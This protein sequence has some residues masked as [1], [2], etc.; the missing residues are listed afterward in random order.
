MSVL[1]LTYTARSASNPVYN[2]LKRIYEQQPAPV[3]WEKEYKLLNM[4]PKRQGFVSGESYT[5]EVEYSG[6][7]AYQ[8]FSKS[9]SYYNTSNWARFTVGDTDCYSEC[10]LDA[11]TLRRV[12][13]GNRD[14]FVRDLAVSYRKHM[15]SVIKRIA[16]GITRDDN[17]YIGTISAVD[18]SADTITMTMKKDAHFFFKGQK[19]RFSANANG[20][21]PRSEDTGSGEDWVVEAVNKTTGVITLEGIKSGTAITAGD[22]VFLE[23]DDK[24]T[25]ASW[26]GLA[27][28]I[29]Y[30]APTLGADS[31]TSSALDRGVAPEDLAGWRFDG[32]SLGLD[33]A[34][35]MA[36]CDGSYSGE[37]PTHLAMAPRQFLELT[38]IAK[39]GVVREPRDNRFGS[40]VATFMGPNGEVGIISDGTIPENRVYGL[41]LET[42]ELL[43]LTDDLVELSMDDGL[44]A[45]RLADSDGMA[46]RVRSW[47]QLICRRPGDNFVIG[48]NT[49]S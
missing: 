12:K 18:H 35:E 31:F 28:W 40:A 14:S 7:A 4:I 47:S 15:M 29:P 42:W 9:Q 26:L 21:S 13:G 19:L 37:G 5:F 38:K 48:V 23:G 6:P 30:T 20:S 27:S 34:I 16:Y 22:Y 1:P 43:H 3:L 36:L 25:Q 8:N 41:N 33:D 2:I 32:T 11:K 45:A 10:R 24:T 44:E 46:Y 49:V 17:G 39:A